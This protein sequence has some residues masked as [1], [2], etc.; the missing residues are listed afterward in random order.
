M[1]TFL[2][3][4]TVSIFIFSILSFSIFIELKLLANPCDGLNNKSPQQESNKIY[5]NIGPH[6]AQALIDSRPDIIIIDAR[7]PDEFSKGHLN[8]ARLLNV[9]E[10]E[11]YNDILELPIDGTYLVYCK[12]GTRSTQA[13][14]LMAG[15]GFKNI[16]NLDGGFD[17][18]AGHGLPIATSDLVSQ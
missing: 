10:S 8:R 14:S 13:I 9:Q 3:K 18:W 16:Y 15:E 7:T 6:D 11:F 4:I 2:Q 17:S 12:A 1:K 5:I